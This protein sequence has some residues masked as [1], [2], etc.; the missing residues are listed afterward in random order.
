[1]GTE[2]AAHMKEMKDVGPE[3]FTHEVKAFVTRR[4]EL[5]LNRGLPITELARESDF[6]QEFYDSFLQER[7]ARSVELN[8]TAIK[9]ANQTILD[10]FGSKLGI[11][12][13]MDGRMPLTAL[14][15]FPMQAV[16]AMRLPGGDL[17]GFK[18]NLSTGSLEP[19]SEAL[20]TQLTRHQESNGSATKFEV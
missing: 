19:D 6:L 11:V 13:C 18:R 17:G 20:F 10:L 3:H 2:H 16:R 5:I 15:G 9:E 7:H 14:F 4:T 1:M 12:S 8:S